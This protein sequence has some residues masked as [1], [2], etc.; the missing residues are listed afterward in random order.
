MGV[1][2][3]VRRSTWFR[4]TTGHRAMSN[5]PPYFS[6]AESDDDPA[7]RDGHRRRTVARLAGFDA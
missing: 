1:T 7:R 5:E 2:E 6:I 3:T 4:R